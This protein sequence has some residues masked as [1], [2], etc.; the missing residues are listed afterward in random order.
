MTKKIVS[1]ATAL[2]FLALYIHVATTGVQDMLSRQAP[3][4]AATIIAAPA[5]TG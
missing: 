3:A 5:H 4:Q 2:G 1:F